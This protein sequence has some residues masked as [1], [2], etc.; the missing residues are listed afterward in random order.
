MAL[1]HKK[2]EGGLISSETFNLTRITT[3]LGGALAVLTATVSGGTAGDNGII[4]A[5]FDSTQRTALLVAIVAAIAAISVADILGR[6]VAAGK[7]ENARVQV[8]GPRRAQLT[9]GSDGTV[10]AYRPVPAPQV[11]FVRTGI[12]KPAPSWENLDQVHLLLP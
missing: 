6:A 3:V 2:N 8:I 4:W 12:D 5:E 9:D 1:L 11:L 10:V 7:A